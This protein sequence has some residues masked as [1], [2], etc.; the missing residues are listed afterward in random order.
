MGNVGEKGGSLNIGSAVCKTVPTPRGIA[1][2]K[3]MGSSLQF[4]SASFA[5]ECRGTGRS[6]LKQHHLD[7]PSGPQGWIQRLLLGEEGDEHPPQ[8]SFIC[9]NAPCAFLIV[10]A[11]SEI[12]LCANVCVLSVSCEMG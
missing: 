1:V 2:T 5:V 3:F 10:S 7:G 4:A 11:T 12:C 8:C 9:Y 6:G